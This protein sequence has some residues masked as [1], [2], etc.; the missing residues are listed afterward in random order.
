MAGEFERRRYGPL[1]DV[2]GCWWAMHI[3]VPLQ[4]R[5]LPVDFVVP[6]IRTRT[7][8]K[9]RGADAQNDNG[10][11]SWEKR[12][13]QMQVLRLCWSRDAVSNLARMT[14]VFEFCRK[15]TQRQRRRRLWVERYGWFGL[16]DVFG[17][18]RFAQD[19]S[20]NKQRRGQ[21]TA[22]AKAK[23]GFSAGWNSA[24]KRIS[25]LRCSR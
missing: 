20:R 6:K 17:I 21:A 25:P 5:A 18:L 23:C 10:E 1:Q 14:K 24:E 4:D 3:S 9:R 2:V 12:Q 15:N 22:T 7:K 19:Y 11:S 8:P 16:V 13:R